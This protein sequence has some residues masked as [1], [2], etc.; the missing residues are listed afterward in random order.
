[1]LGAFISTVSAAI[2]NI[3]KIVHHERPQHGEVFVIHLQQLIGLKHWTDAEVASCGIGGAICH[4]RIGHWWRGR[5][6]GARR[7]RQLRRTLCRLILFIYESK[8]T[9]HNCSISLQ[10]TSNKFNLSHRKLAT[11]YTRHFYNFNGYLVE[12]NKIIKKNLKQISLLQV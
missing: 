7:R 5:A 12:L 2:L 3:F 11:I 6:E 10:T 8:N 1:M 4:W 9:T